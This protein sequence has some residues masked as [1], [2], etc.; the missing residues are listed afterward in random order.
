MSSTSDMNIKRQIIRLFAIASCM[1]SVILMTACLG[2]SGTEPTGDVSITTNWR[3]ASITGSDGEVLQRM[4][5]ETD[6]MLPYFRCD[7]TVFEMSVVQGTVRT[8]TVTENE[9]GTYTLTSDDNGKEFIADIDGDTLVIYFPENRELTF[10]A[11]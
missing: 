3:F 5:W 8:G 7:G 4:P 6:D 10:E 1:V 11:E 2:K 9:D